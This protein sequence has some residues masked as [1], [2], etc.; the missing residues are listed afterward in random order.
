MSEENARGMLIAPAGTPV[1]LLGN[2]QHKQLETCLRIIESTSES[3]QEVA[4]HLALHHLLD[5]YRDGKTL[6]DTPLVS[7]EG[8]LAAQIAWWLAERESSPDHNDDDFY[9][10]LY[11]RHGS[12]KTL[13]DDEQEILGNT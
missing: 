12:L 5:T 4:F 8:V 11:Y 9:G 2:Y 13:T 6:S 3:P 1:D 10:V 7:A